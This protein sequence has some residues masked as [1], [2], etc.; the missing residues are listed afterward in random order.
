MQGFAILLLV[1]IGGLG[2]WWVVQ[3]LLASPLQSVGPSRH[4]FGVVLI[5]GKDQ[6]VEHTFHLRNTT[7]RPLKII[8]TVPSCGCTWAG[9]GEPNLAPGATMELPVTLTVKESHKID[10]SIKVVLEGETPLVLWLSAEGR[11]QE[12]L[13]HA[14]KFIRI[15][16]AHPDATGRLFLEWWGEELPPPP[17]INSADSLKIDFAGWELQSRGSRRLG[18]PDRY[19]GLLEIHAVDTPPING[20]IQATMPD[21]RTT[22]IPVNPPGSLGEMRTGEP[23]FL[24]DETNIEFNP[25]QVGDSEPGDQPEQA[26]GDH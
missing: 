1:A 5:D 2:A 19:M 12:G 20:L 8:K 13:R 7:T 4:D 16:P 17:V 21:A 9:P 23:M 18:T 10:S 3:G 24:P 26:P 14:P 22:R 11:I 6:T 15:K 25:E